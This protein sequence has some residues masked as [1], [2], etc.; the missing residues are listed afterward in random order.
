MSFNHGNKWVTIGEENDVLH[1]Y[2]KE[3][4][5]LST[6][7][8]KMRSGNEQ[9]EL[10]GEKQEGLLLRLEF[11]G[12]VGQSPRPPELLGERVAR[13]WIC[14]SQSGSHRQGTR[15]PG[16]DQLKRTVGSSLGSLL[17]VVMRA[18]LTNQVVQDRQSGDDEAMAMDETFCMA[19]EYGLPPTG[20]WGMGID[21]LLMLL[22]D[23]QNIKVFFFPTTKPHD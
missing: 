12:E 22:T 2:T 14:S 4:L 5:K 10:V 20:S 3:N 16:K 15:L 9:E 1:P 7:R 23:S 8:V 21:R 11:T 6:I 13:F 17:R 18:A 19:L